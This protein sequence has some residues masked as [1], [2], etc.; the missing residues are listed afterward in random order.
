MIRPPYRVVILVASRD[1]QLQKALEQ[2]QL[3]VDEGAHRL[4]T[5][6]HW[7]GW[8]ETGKSL[9]TGQRIG[10]HIARHQL[11]Q[12]SVAMLDTGGDM[13]SRQQI[14]VA[15]HGQTTRFCQ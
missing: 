7:C 6:V 15:I 8:I 3:A 2:A 11:G 5:H 14:E 1:A 9:R 4:A 10:R 12:A 13:R